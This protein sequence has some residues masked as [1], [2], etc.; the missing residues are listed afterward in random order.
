M[1]KVDIVRVTTKSELKRF[2]DLPWSIYSRDSLW[3]PP[4]K[5]QVRRLLD[6]RKHPFWKFSE[7][8][9]FLARRGTE[10]VGRVAG[11]IDNNYNQYHNENMGAWGF[12]ECRDDPEAAQALLSAVEEWVRKNGMSFLRGPLNPSTN[13]EVGMLMEGFEHPPMVM[14]PWNHP[15]YV[16]LIE[17]C[18]FEKEKDLVALRFTQN[19][20]MGERFARL[21]KRVQ[22][23]GK[24]WKR[25]GSKKDVESEMRLI[26]E[27]YRSAWADNWGFVPTTDD[28][29]REMARDLLYVMEEELCCFVYHGDQPV[30]VAMAFLDIN[31]LLK[32][33]N[34]RLGLTAIFKYLRYRRE[35]KGI[36][37]AVLGVKREFRNLGIP[38]LAFDHFYRL[39]KGN[40]KYADVELGWN[41]EDNDAINKMELQLG[42][43]VYKKYRIFRKSF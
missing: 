37:G 17:G 8:I 23:N 31:P 9:L 43:H 35:P 22:R 26:A 11:I 20:T 33:L 12:F 18:G 2:V 30:A 27:I 36:R 42:A 34:G 39:G 10:V 41:L 40:P 28:E 7:Q 15:Y 29:N 24:I 21:A 13:Y 25:L 5:R 14:M 6:T 1:S 19:D 3:V 32:R 16:P 4:L 38:L